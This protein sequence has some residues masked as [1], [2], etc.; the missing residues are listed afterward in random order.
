MW[1]IFPFV[2]FKYIVVLSLS[3]NFKYYQIW[4]PNQKRTRKHYEDYIDMVTSS[5]YYL[6]AIKIQK[7]ANLYTKF[8]TQIYTQK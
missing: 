1:N 7:P 5:F 2:L 3:D 8:V 6:L 4:R